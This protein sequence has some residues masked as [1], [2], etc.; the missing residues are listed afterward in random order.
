M[1]SAV[2]ASIAAAQYDLA[3][4]H[5]NYGQR[6]ELR[7]LHCF[8]LLASH[9][10]AKHRLV[11]DLAHFKQIGG[12]S[13]LEGD[14]E[15]PKVDMNASIGHHI[16][17]TYVPFRNGILLAIAASW[18]EVLGAK[19]I[20]LGAV[21]QDSSGY[22]DCRPEFMLAMNQ[23]ISAGT[24]PNTQ[25]EIETPLIHLTKKQIVEQGRI[26]N[27]PFELTYSCYQHNDFACGACESCVLRL[28]AF[29]QAGDKDPIVYQS[30][31]DIHKA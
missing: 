23:A 30:C 20:F 6:T 11:L 16:P 17:S 10:G 29:L 22:P 5:A 27:T 21:M 15:V 31:V 26:L 14:E 1:D 3:F 24:K 19:K 4:L 7:E 28:R 18:A 12:S 25:I 2:C 8:H 9:F 13:L